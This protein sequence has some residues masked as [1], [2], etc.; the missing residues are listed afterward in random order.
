MSNSTNIAAKWRTA[1]KALVEA[2]DDVW[3]P[4]Y[5]PSWCVQPD[6]SVV[7]PC[8]AAGLDVSKCYASIDNVPGDWWDELRRRKRSGE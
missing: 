1:D 7:V 4:S 6:G 8:Y 2:G 3:H 5:S